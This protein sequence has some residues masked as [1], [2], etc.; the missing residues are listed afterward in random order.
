MFSGYI[1]QEI[2]NRLQATGATVV[3]MPGGRL[4]IAGMPVFGVYAREMV[5]SYEHGGTMVYT[6][7][8]PLNKFRLITCGF[9]FGVAEEVADLIN[10]LA[11][12]SDMTTSTET[13]LQLQGEH[14]E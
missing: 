10:D 9:P 8:R 6:G 14:H 12:Q 11:G 13:I 2:R 3:G 1:K 4:F 5:V 7:D